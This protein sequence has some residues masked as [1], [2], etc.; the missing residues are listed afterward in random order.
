MHFSEITIIELQFGEKLIY[1]LFR[2]SNNFLKSI[3]NTVTTM[4]F[5]VFERCTATVFFLDF[6]RPC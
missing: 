3:L 6:N 5:V 4:Y 1:I 2:I